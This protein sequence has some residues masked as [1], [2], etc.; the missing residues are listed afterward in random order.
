MTRD[1]VIA[2]CHK[3]CVAA[4]NNDE[5]MFRFASAIEARVREECA[6][7]CDAIETDKFALYKGRSP[8]TGQDP[9]RAD[10]YTNG[11]SDGAGQC[12]TAIRAAMPQ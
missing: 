3:F 10:P 11:E 4:I 7:I 5:D 1:E 9:G 12:A 6:V 2:L 8:Y